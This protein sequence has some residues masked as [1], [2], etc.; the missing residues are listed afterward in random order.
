MNQASVPE[1]APAGASTSVP[2]GVPVGDLSALLETVAE[3]LDDPTWL[4]T[5]RRE[6][7]ERY[8]A[9]AWPRGDEEMWRR[10][11]LRNAPW[12]QW[13]LP[14]AEDASSP[15]PLPSWLNGV[16]RDD[17]AGV[18]MH[19]DA[20][21]LQEELAQDLAQRG[22]LLAPLSQAAREY[23]DL[24][25]R[26][27][28]A[29]LPADSDR[30]T[31]LSAALWTQGLFCYVPRGVHVDT[32]LY[33]LKTSQ[34]DGAGILGQTL[35]VVEEGASLTLVEATASTS[36][37]ASTR[38]PAFSHH[39]LEIVAEADTQV[40]VVLVQNWGDNVSAFVTARARAGREANVQIAS[41][42]FGGRLH[43]ERLTM[44]LAG[45]GARA[46]LLGIFV[47]VGHQHVEFNTRQ[48]HTA[49]RG[50]STLLIKGALDG[51][52]RAV[53]YGVIKIF[54]EGQRTVAQQTLRNLLLSGDAEADP[55]PVLEIEADDVK[56][57]HAAAVGPVDP[58][59]LFYLQARGIPPEM[60]ERMVVQGFLDVVVDRLP[61]AHLRTVVESLVERKLQEEPTE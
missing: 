40:H 25:Q 17:A 28:H 23:P 22:V 3:T 12:Q 6:A 1:H 34:A 46:D 27:L 35:I 52:A 24:V 38:A 13:R 16:A 50:E 10:T 42:V 2:V 39:S 41:A 11:P 5:R 18:I 37:P 14:L 44:D 48:D 32:P 36:H 59:H 61:D 20:R 53:Q 51:H 43:K 30:F 33:H 49:E 54:P 4:R 60:A 57:A 29:L 19:A 47:A 7:L 45:E 15:P 21:L 56:C 8:H 55:I 31:A 26:H 58:E 9:L